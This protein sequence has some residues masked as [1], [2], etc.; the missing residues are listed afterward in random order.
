MYEI[1]PPLRNIETQ[2]I[3]LSGCENTKKYRLSGLS[4]PVTMVTA[5]TDNHY[6]GGALQYTRLRIFTNANFIMFHKYR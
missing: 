3:L 5:P 4:G 1:G 6:S 2:G